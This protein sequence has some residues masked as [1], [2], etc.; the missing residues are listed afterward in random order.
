MQTVYSFVHDTRALLSFTLILAKA[1]HLVNHPRSE[2]CEKSWAYNGQWVKSRLGLRRQSESDIERLLVN[3]IY[4]PHTKNYI[5]RSGVL[6]IATHPCDCCLATPLG[7]Q[8]TSPLSDKVP[9]LWVLCTVIL[10]LVRHL[11]SHSEALVRESLHHN[12]LGTIRRRSEFI[13]VILAYLEYSNLRSCSQVA[14]LEYGPFPLRY[15][16]ILGISINVNGWPF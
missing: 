7:F 4:P 2:L 9:L 8:P 16:Y 12:P 13:P 6:C 3:L 1:H 14:L 15:Y 5:V 11:G 10:A